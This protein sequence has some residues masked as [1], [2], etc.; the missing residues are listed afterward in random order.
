MSKSKK[1][2]SVCMYNGASA[3][4]HS[5]LLVKRLYPEAKLYLT[6]IIRSKPIKPSLFRLNTRSTHQNIR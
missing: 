6:V 1:Y 4:E 5:P 2:K 3:Y